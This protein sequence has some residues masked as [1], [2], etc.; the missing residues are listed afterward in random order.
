MDKEEQLFMTLLAQFNQKLEKQEITQEDI[1]QNN[2]Y[3]VFVTFKGIIL[4][5]NLPE[6]D[7]NT[8][9]YLIDQAQRHTTFLKVLQEHRMERK[10][11]LHQQ[12]NAKYLVLPASELQDGIANLPMQIAFDEMYKEAALI[13]KY[14]FQVRKEEGVITDL[15]PILENLIG[16]TQSIYINARELEFTDNEWLEYLNLTEKST[17]KG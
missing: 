7:Q 5:Y 9:E 15:K 2:D 8:K 10:R 3:G 11:K 12:K 1:V 16:L 6:F 4:N 14:F 13:G 17:K